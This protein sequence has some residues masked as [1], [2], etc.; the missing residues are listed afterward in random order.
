MSARE[1]RCVESGAGAETNQPP[2]GNRSPFARDE[3]SNIAKPINPSEG[4]NSAN[5]PKILAAVLPKIVDWRGFPGN[6]R[7]DC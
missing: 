7:T 5:R 2:K 4:E 3:A 1:I 6:D